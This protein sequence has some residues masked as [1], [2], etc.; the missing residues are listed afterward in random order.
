MKISSLKK[1]KI[2]QLEKE[3]KK[4]KERGILNRFFSVSPK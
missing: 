3:L 1:K 2:V 4:E